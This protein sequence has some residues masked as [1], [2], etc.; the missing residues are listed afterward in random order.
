[1]MVQLGPT[2]DDLDL[3]RQRPPRMHKIHETTD[4]DLFK[5]TQTDLDDADASPGIRDEDATGQGGPYKG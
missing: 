1:M 2:Q 5:S 3:G 4:L